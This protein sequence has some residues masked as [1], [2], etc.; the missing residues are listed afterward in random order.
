[1][2]FDAAGRRIDRPA[3]RN[4]WE[5]APDDPQAPVVAPVDP[6]TLGID[7]LDLMPSRT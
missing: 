2:L 5:A 1:V 7:P 6:S 3:E 4:L